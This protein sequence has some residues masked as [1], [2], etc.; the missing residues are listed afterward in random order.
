MA[1][2]VI[3]LNNIDPAFEF[4]IDL[5][6]DTYTFDFHYNTRIGLWFFSI[7]KSFGPPS[8]SPIPLIVEF[9]LTDNLKTAAIPP[10]TLIAI[11]ESGQEI[12]PGREDLG[13]RVKLYYDDL[14]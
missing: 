13:N 3:P 1:I 8:V 10:G 4:D 2:K 5:D 7:A 9:P 6:G 11:D 12:D 14:T